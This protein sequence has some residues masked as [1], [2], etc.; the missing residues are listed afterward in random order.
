MYKLIILAIFSMLLMQCG[1]EAQDEDIPKKDPKSI[2]LEDQM[3][4]WEDE[5]CIKKYKR[6]YLEPGEGFYLPF[7]KDLPFD[8]K[9]LY[10]SLVR[11]KIEIDPNND[12]L[13]QKQKDSPERYGTGF[14][15]SSDGYLF[16]AYHVI[17]HCLDSK[18][19]SSEHINVAADFFKCDISFQ[20]YFVKNQKVTKS[21][22]IKSFKIIYIPTYSDAMGGIDNFDEE[23]GS[24]ADNSK[25]YDFALLKLD[26]G[27]Y[28]HLKVNETHIEK[29]DTD[30]SL[31]MTGFPVF[32]HRQSKFYPDAFYETY[33]RVTVGNF[34]KI[35]N[36]SILSNNDSSKGISGGPIVNDSLLLEGIVSSGQKPKNCTTI[37]C[38]PPVSSSVNIREVIDFLHNKNIT[39]N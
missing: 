31:Y 10:E 2:C 9:R 4:L 32:V 27:P 23:E 1:K 25:I 12:A 6:G 15:V 5:K 17:R 16:T 21:K 38:K 39:F 29:L 36:N 28:Q 8:E 24:L 13:S 11:I 26:T 37:S 30:I 34:I 18:A 19:R 7:T 22:I 20:T 3:M 33:P 14:F 35:Q